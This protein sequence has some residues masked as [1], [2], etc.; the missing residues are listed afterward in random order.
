MPIENHAMKTRRVLPI[1]KEQHLPAPMRARNTGNIRGGTLIELMLALSIVGILASLAIP[2]YI[3]FL[4]KARVARV[5]SELHA[6]AKEIKGFTIGGG[7]YPDTLAQ[8]GRSTML[9]RWE[10][11]YQYY[12]MNCAADV[13]IMNLAKLKLRKKKPPR[14]LPDHGSPSTTTDWHIMLAVDTDD[15]R[16]TLC[17]NGIGSGTSCRWSVRCIPGQSV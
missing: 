17:W 10:S 6:L 4:E 12:R 9:D 2:N 11:R 3:D 5:V 14:V 16:D 8:I 7:G 13:E 1:S 15:H